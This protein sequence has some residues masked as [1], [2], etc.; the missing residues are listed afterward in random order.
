M[1]NINDILKECADAE[2]LCTYMYAR[3][4]EANRLM[5]DVRQ[6]PVLLRQFDET[7]SAST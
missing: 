2:G 3:I 7:I 1:K 5:D 6:F 4:G